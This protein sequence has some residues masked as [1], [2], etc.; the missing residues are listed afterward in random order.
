M[1]DKASAVSCR[2]CAE[3][4]F[5]ESDQACSIL[6]KVENCFQYSKIED[7][8]KT[9]QDGHILAQGECL[10]LPKM[11]YCVEFHVEKES[12]KC[13]RCSS[14]S[15]LNHQQICVKRSFS[16]DMIPHCGEL[17][18]HHDKCLTCSGEFDMA[19]DGLACLPLVQHCSQH[20]LVLSDRDYYQCQKCQDSFTL[21]SESNACFTSLPGCV[22][23]DSLFQNCLACDNQLF[24]I[25]SENKCQTRN[26]KPLQCQE[27]ETRSDQ[28]KVCHESFELTT[29]SLECLPSVSHC[30][31]IYT[32]RV[33]ASNIK[34]PVKP[35]LT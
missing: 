8:C 1:A 23:Y 18:P 21:R 14:M 27:Y 7:K 3:S 28:C 33:I 15:Y 16:L 9:C 20:K 6:S 22:Q 29:D 19:P 25:N 32:I 5:K 34:I 30:S 10:V 35:H 11:E 31:V 4:H 12:L 2:Q 17:D 13:K 26:E 24:F